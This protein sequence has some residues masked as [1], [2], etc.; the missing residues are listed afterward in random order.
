MFTAT[1]L[2]QLN[3][4]TDVKEVRHIINV[5]SMVNHAYVAQN[6]FMVTIKKNKTK[7]IGNH[8]FHLNASYIG[9]DKLKI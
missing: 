7:H 8:Y 6:A 3:L 5:S 4:T 2:Q 9:F 1:T